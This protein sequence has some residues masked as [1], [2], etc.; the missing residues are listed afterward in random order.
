MFGK[1]PKH[2]INDVCDTQKQVEQDSQKFK[3]GW[4]DI[5]KMNQEVLELNC[6]SHTFSD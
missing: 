4:K 1:P 3:P 5:F 6:K 2:K